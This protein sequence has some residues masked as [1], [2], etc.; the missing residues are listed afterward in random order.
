MIYLDNAATTQM[1]QV[2]LEAMIDISGKCYGNA[3]S[4]YS[5]GREAG[6]VLDESR[7]I[8]ANCIG[9]EPDEIYFTSGGTESNNWAISQAYS[10]EFNKVITSQIEHHAILNP[11]ERLK[12]SGKKISYLPVDKNC[13]VLSEALLRELD[14]T[15]LFVSI[16]LQNN[17]TGAIQPIKNLSES[18]HRDNARSI[19]HT[20]AVQAI[21]HMKV[22]VKELGV[23]ILSA[24]AHKFNGPKGVGFLYVRKGCELSPYILGGG[25]EKGLRSG[26]ENVA[27]I[28]AM[29]KALEENVLEINANLKQIDIL[30]NRLL[31]EL[32][33][34]QVIF[35]LNVDSN[36]RAKGTIS[37]SVDGVDGEGLLNM[38]DARG[39]CVS[40]GSACNSKDKERSHV[41]KAM[42]CSDEIIDSTIRIS[43]GRYNTEE[44]ILEFVKILKKIQELSKLAKM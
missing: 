36:L 12:K 3:S 40:V 6:K 7:K 41:L 33:R 27:G 9:A 14:G 16:M 22:D 18:V 39:I 37:I 38:L 8:I 5:L 20:D 31:D 28:Y 2:A 13:C 23:D 17:E 30:E 34:Q 35:L 4:L 29:A 32:K 11:V 44:D 42:A 26:T 15:R 21:G 10:C 24:S 19:F 25:Q 43:I 1:S